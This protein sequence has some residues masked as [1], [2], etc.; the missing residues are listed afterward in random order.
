MEAIDHVISCR[1]ATLYSIVLSCTGKEGPGGDP[2]PPR[3][4]A[5]HSVPGLMFIL[6]SYFL[7]RST[8]WG[9]R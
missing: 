2:S 6:A 9:F 3:P 7:F 8:L 1:A 4:R 5:G